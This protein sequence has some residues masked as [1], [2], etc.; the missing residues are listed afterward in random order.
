SLEP[1][2]QKEIAAFIAMEPSNMHSVL[3]RLQ[4]RGL[5]LVRQSRSDRRRHEIRLSKAG[6]TLFSAIEPLEAEVGPR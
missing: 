3:R 1:A 6:R 2:T 4:E 5:V